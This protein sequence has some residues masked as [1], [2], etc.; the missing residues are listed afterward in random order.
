MTISQSFT[1]KVKSTTTTILLLI[2]LIFSC[3]SIFAQ[4]GIGIA[5]PHA[6]A[7][8]QIESDNKGFLPPRMN[9]SQRNS[10]T[11]SLTPPAGL[12]IYCT[13]CGTGGELQ[14]YNGSQWTNLAGGTAATPFVC[15]TSTITFQSLTYGTV[16]RAYGGSVGTKCWLDRNLGATRA[17]TTA[18][19]TDY[20]SYGDLYQWGR[21]RD[22]HQAITWTS[23][24]A[25]NMGA[26]TTTLSGLD[27]P[28][29]ANFIIGGNP[30]YDWRS[31][32]NNSLWQ[33]VNGENNPCPSGWRLPTKE[34]WEAEIATWSTR[35]VTTANNSLLKLPSA[36]WR[37]S[38]GSLTNQNTGANYWSSTIVYQSTQQVFYSQVLRL[39]STSTT[40]AGSFTMGSRADGASVRCIKD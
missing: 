40:S 34:E 9:E 15:G 2:L 17:F 4:V 14:V 3:Y 13:N 21:G 26:T 36:G 7:K 38:G 29:N 5:T 6:S 39:N 30:T 25:G 37:S 11:T 8:L 18:S 24:T 10:M 35:D 19:T 27:Q 1:V 31:P 23:N 32:Q 20:Q 12:M 16:S 28:A 33:G 22:G